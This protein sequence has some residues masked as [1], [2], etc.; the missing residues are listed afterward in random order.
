MYLT[1]L[2]EYF[3]NS[4]IGDFRCTYRWIPFLHIFITG[5]SLL[6]CFCCLKRINW[7]RYLFWL[8][9]W[10]WFWL[11]LF[12]LVLNLYQIWAVLF[13]VWFGFT[14]P[15]KTKIDLPE[16]RAII[17]SETNFCFDSINWNFLT[18]KAR[19][20]L[21]NRRMYFPKISQF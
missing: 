8:Q 4:R 18:M 19:C 6:M 12:V 9:L 21:L 3:E 13:S 17:K 20:S 7:M 2:N 11:D 16:T 1:M 5:N 14:C 15:M 10:S